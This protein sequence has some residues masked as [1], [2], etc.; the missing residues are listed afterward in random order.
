MFNKVVLSLLIGTMAFVAPA[1]GQSS[2]WRIDS[3]HSAARLSLA[4]SRNPS[5]ADNVGVARTSGVIEQNSSDSTM[6][7]FDFT[8]YPADKTEAQSGSNPG[9]TVIS[10]KSTHVFPVDKETIRVAGDLTL[11][12]VGRVSTYDP[13]EAYSGP[14]YGPTVH[15]SVTQEGVF[16]FHKVSPGTI[17]NTQDQSAE[18]LASNTT[19]GEDFPQLMN[20]VS[21]TNWPAFVADENC[22]PPSNVGEDFSG[23]ACTGEGVNRIARADVQCAAPTV[24]EDFAG[25]VCTETAPVEVAN[26]VQMQLDLHV[27]R[28]APATTAI[29]GQ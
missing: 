10:F 2:V 3:E 7:D 22:T 19:V 9:Y 18:W 25:E 17:R 8:I 21:T 16:E 4:S 15:H 13:S 5:T 28:T 26:E 12:Y 20:A 6:S 23:I 11:D 29:S 27:T 14:V 24:G 1:V